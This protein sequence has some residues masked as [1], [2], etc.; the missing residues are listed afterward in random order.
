[1]N[2]T[3][4]LKV[5]NLNGVI[6]PEIIALANH[7]NASVKGFEPLQEGDNY[8]DLKAKYESLKPMKGAG[9]CK[10]L[11]TKEF[12]VLPFESHPQM[13]A[14]APKIAEVLTKS[15]IKLLNWDSLEDEV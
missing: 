15:E 5:A 6:E 13:T 7:R 8:G 12:W 9:Y 10:R 4:Y 11:N 14:P 2:N 3:V 1:M